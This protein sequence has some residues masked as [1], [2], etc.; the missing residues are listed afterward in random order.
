MTKPKSK[1]RKAAPK[2]PASRKGHSRKTGQD[3]RGAVIRG[4]D[5]RPETSRVE[6]IRAAIK[7]LESGEP[8]ERCAE[9]LAATF[10]V[11]PRQANRYIRKAR[12]RMSR[13]LEREMPHARAQRV[14]RLMR[15]S[16][17]AEANDDAKGM[18]AAEKAIGELQGLFITKVAAVN[19][20]LTDE[21]AGTLAALALNP[22]DQA[23]RLRE[24]EDKARSAPPPP[25]V[26][27]E[28]A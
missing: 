16:V 19:G 3:L 26:T 9:K 18:V 20:G 21:Q 4:P 23:R 8:P 12:E 13:L 28:D 25:P 6:R 14:R 10:R 27:N 17:L 5:S 1:K 11:T 22:F 24:L 7:L 2:K 15:A